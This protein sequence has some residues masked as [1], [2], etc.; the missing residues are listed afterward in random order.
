MAGGSEAP[1]TSVGRV[2]NPLLTKERKVHFR[3]WKSQN[4]CN[5]SS[6]ML[7]AVQSYQH[8]RHQDSAVKKNMLTMDK[9]G[10]VNGKMEIIKKN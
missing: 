4:L 9:K 7:S 5:L 8:T 2:I 10:S 1:R 6:T 3:E